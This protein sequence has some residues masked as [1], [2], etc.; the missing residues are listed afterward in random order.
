MRPCDKLTSGLFKSHAGGGCGSAFRGV[1]VMNNRTMGV[2]AL[3]SVLALASTPGYALDFNFSFTGNPGLGG[4]TGT[5]K[6]EIDGLLDNATSPATHVI[7]NSYPATLTLGISAPFDAIF[8]T[9]TDNQFTVS[10][11]VLTIGTSIFNSSSSQ[12]VLRLELADF[13]LGTVL[14]SNSNVLADSATFTLVPSVPGPI[15]GAG[16][17]GLIFAGG[18]LLGWWRRRQK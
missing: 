15:A 1:G 9:V 13:Q 3:A 4:V 2:F 14:N 7:V 6:G 5:V 16:L 8:A 10:S 11:G 17:P 12:F 18:G